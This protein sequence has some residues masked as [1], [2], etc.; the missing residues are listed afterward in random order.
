[1]DLLLWRH[2]EAENLVP[3]KIADQQRSLTSEGRRAAQSMAE[4]I[5]KQLPSHTHLLI[6][7]ARRTAMTAEA[8]LS[9]RHFTY[10]YTEAVGLSSNA[11][12]ILAEIEIKQHTNENSVLIVGHQPTLGQVAAKLL[13]GELKGWEIEKGGL[14]WFKLQWGQAQLHMVLSP[15]LFFS[16]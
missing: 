11:E 15:S 3:G 13:T 4:L 12:C 6:S 1:M 9:C 2:C 5:A 14:W 7:P 16:S 10:E 8:L